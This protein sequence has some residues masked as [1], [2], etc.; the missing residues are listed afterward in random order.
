MR[1]CAVIVLA[2]CAGGKGSVTCTPLV[3]GDWTIDG[4]A[5]GMP[6]GATVTMDAEGCTFSFSDWS[7]EMLSLPI[8]GSLDGSD[9]AMDGDAHWSS[10]AGTVNEDG[11]E[12]SGRCSDDGTE[13][14]MVQ[15][16]LTTGS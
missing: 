13:F 10:C 1:W 2:G 3:S 14:T 8:G 6:M 7:M 15:T 12:V 4:S 11:T 5:M 16:P 9:L